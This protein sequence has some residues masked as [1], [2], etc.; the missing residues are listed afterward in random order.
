MKYNPFMI[1]IVVLCLNISGCVNNYRTP[2]ESV[3]YFW[4]VMLK[5][6]KAEVLKTQVYYEFGMTPQYII[7]PENIDWLY[8]DSMSTVY[9]KEN[10][11][12]VYYQVVFKKKGGAKI[13]SYKTG[14]L[15]IKKGN[16]WK[17]AKVIGAK[18]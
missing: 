17:I 10:R 4:S 15:T 12:N 2:E 8:L 18:E 16:N 13:I 6:D 11:A 7:T 9:E 14:T 1:L 5:G 3:K